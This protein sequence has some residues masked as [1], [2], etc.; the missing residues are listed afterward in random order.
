MQGNNTF[1]QKFL[2]WLA[3]VELLGASVASIFEAWQ[4][5]GAWGFAGAAVFVAARTM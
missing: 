1:G 4:V 5:A 3:V 2:G